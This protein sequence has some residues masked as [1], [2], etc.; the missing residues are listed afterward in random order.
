MLR[1]AAM[2][3]SALLALGTERSLGAQEWHG[4]PARLGFVEGESLVQASEMAAWAPAL[5]NTP[6]GPGDRVWVAGRGRAEL[7]LPA[8]NV[9]RLGDETRLEIRA[10]PGGDRP[11]T[12]LGLER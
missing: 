5:S 2:V 7:Q 9:V 1:I 4:E 6:L 12:R 11:E 10:L 8:G 3:A